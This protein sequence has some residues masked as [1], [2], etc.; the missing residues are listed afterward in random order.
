MTTLRQLSL[1]LFAVLALVV[2]ARAEIVIATN[3]TWRYFK[4][5]SE[6]SDPTNLWREVA[7]D[8]SAWLVGA[9]PFHYG[10]NSL[11]GDDNQLGGTI[12]SDMRSNYTCIFMRQPFVVE[13]TNLFLTLKLGFY[14]DDGLVIWLNGRLAR[15]PIR[16]GANWAYTNAA[17]TQGGEA[18]T[19]NTVD[20]SNVITNLVNGTN[21]LCVQAFNG[22]LTNDDFRIDM[23]LS[24]TYKDIV[25][26]V[27]T[28]ALPAPGSAVSSLT[29]I[30]VQFDE[31]VQGVVAA[32]FLVNGD[33]C[34]AV[35]GSNN[36]YTFTFNQPQP[37]RVQ[38]RW[39]INHTVF[40]LSGN[41]L[42]ETAPTASWEYTLI[43]GTP[44][45]VAAIFPRPGATLT[46]LTELEVIFSEPIAGL[47]AADLLIAGQPAS[48]VVPTAAGGYLFRAT[49]AA[50]GAV[51][52]EWSPTHQI[53]DLAPLPNPFAGG[54]WTY[55]LDLTL[56]FANVTIN[57]F[58]AENLTGLK[59]EDTEEQDW[60]EL[61]N[62]G[63]RAIPLLGWSLTDDPAQPRLWEFPDVSINPGQYLVVFA[64]AKDRKPTTPGS[65]LHTNFRLNPYGDYLGLYNP[66]HPPQAVSEFTPQ[67]PEQR[68]NISYGLPTGTN[69]FAYYAT[70]TPG[71]SNPPA[72]VYL[73]M[74]SAPAASV[75]SGLFNQ[76]F[77]VVLSTTTPGASIYYTLNGSP[78]GPT[79]TLYTAPIPVAGTASK[80][81]VLLRAAAYKTNWLSSPITTH[82]YIFPYYVINQPANPAGFPT[83]WNDGGSKNDIPADYEMD[84]QILTNGNNAATAR[85]GL[86]ALPSLSIVTHVD[87]LFGTNKGLYVLR[88]DTY[89]Q[90]VNAELIF[91]DGTPGFNVPAG[92]EIQ[93]GTS[94]NDEGS[95][96]KSKKLSLRL[97]FKGDFGARNLEYPLFP[98][99]PV[100]RFNTLV[101]DNGLNH[102]W[103]YNG[104]SSTEQQRQTAQYT[105]DQ[106]ISDLQLATGHASAH[107]RYTHVYLNGLYWGLTSLHERPD[108][109][110]SAEHLGGDAA[111]YDVLRHNNNNV[112]A[113]NN[114][115]YNAMF[116]A[117]R[118]G[119]A[120]NAAYE[121]FAQQYL[122]VPAFIDYMIINLWSGNNDWAHQN[123]YASRRRAPGGLWRY[124]SW[125]A[126]HVLEST[127]FNWWT[128]GHASDPNGPT[129]LLQ[130]LR[131]NAEFR[132]TFADH[133]HRHFFNA[134]VFA[135]AA[136]TP[137]NLDAPGGN[138]PAALYLQRVRQVEPVLV[139]ESARWGDAG[140]L[141]TDRSNN[142]LTVE[143]DW[144]PELRTLM[145]LTN[146]GG[147]HN[148]QYN[149]FPNRSATV[150]NQFRANG[151][152]PTVPAPVFRQH[153]GRVPAGYALY[154]TNTAGAGTTV[155]YT[156]TGHDPRLY[157]SGAVAPAARVYTNN[158]PVLLDRTVVLKARAWSNTVWSALVE[159]RFTVGEMGIPLRLTELMY[160][161]LPGG[162]PGE[163]YEFVELQNTGGTPLDLQ[164]YYF[165]G[166]SF[167][168]PPG[169]S[170]NAGARL[171]LASDN[172]PLNWLAR[173]PGVTPAGWFDNAL[174]NAGETITLY[175][176]RGVKVTAVTYGSSRPWP[177][178]ANGQGYSLEIIDAEGDPNDPANWRASA[179]PGGTPGLAPT[180]VTPPTLVL[181]EIMA[182]NVSAVTND[183]AFPDWIELHNPG[184]NP[185]S[186]A[187][188][189]LTDDGNPRKFVFPPSVPDLDAGQ[190]L[191]VW[192]DTN[193]AAPGLHTGFALGRLGENL[194]LYDA[195]TNRVDALSYGP[196]V[197][198][199]TLGR[200][201]PPGRPSD[202]WT[203]CLPT[204]GAAN[205]AALL[206]SATNLVLNEWLANPP[207]GGADWIELYNP[208]ASAPVALRGAYFSFSNTIVQLCSWSFVPA[209]GFVRLWADELPGG[210]HLDFKL[211]KEGG[212]LALYDETGAEVNR[213]N[214]GAQA[215]NVTQ[216]RLPNGSATTVA[217]PNS[218][219]P[220]A[221]NYV[222]AYTGPRLN[223]VLARN[224][225]AV[226]GPS[227]N[228]PDWVELVN[229]NGSAFDLS[230]MSL[231]D[232]PTE[233]GKWVFPAGVSIAANDY[234]VVWCDNSRPAST[235]AGGCLNTGFALDGTSGGV[236][237]FNSLGQR[238]DAVEYGFQLPDVSIGLAGGTWRLL[239]SPTPGSANSTPA[240]LGAVANVRINEW[241]ADTTT[242]SDWF[243]LYNLDSLPVNLAG[244]YLTDDP[245]ITG[246]TNFQVGPL[247]FIGGKSWVVWQ[248]DGDAGEGRDHVNFALDALG[249]TLRLYASPTNLIDAVDFGLQTTNVSRGRLADGAT[250]L[251]SFPTSPS[252]GGANYLPLADVVINEV[253][254]HTDPPLE[255]A[256]ELHNPSTNTVDLSGWYLSNSESDLKRYRIPPGTVLTNGGFTVFYEYQF[257][258]NAG[259]PPSFALNSAHGDEVYLAQATN[260]VLTGYRASV[261]FGAS[262]NG[263]SL[264]RHQTSVGA[265]FVA[266]SAR[267]FGMD[268]PNTLAEFRTGTGLP[269]ADPQVGPLV[270]NEIM[271]HPVSG[272]GGSES[273]DEEFIEIYNISSNTVSLFDPAHTTNRWKLDGAVAYEFP[274]TASLGAGEYLLVVHFDPWS[275]P[276]ALANFQAK[277][278]VATNVPIL[279]PWSGR[280]DNAGEN[281][282]LYQPDAPQTSPPDAGFVPFILVDRVNYDDAAPWPTNGVDGGGASLQRLTSTAYG[283]DPVNWKAEAPT[284]GGE[285][286]A[287]PSVP[288]TLSLQPQS[289]VAIAGNSVVFSVVAAGTAPLSYQWQLDGSNIPGATEASYTIPF[290]QTNDAGNYRVVVSN[291][292]NSIVSQ[293]ASLTVLVPPSIVSLVP[294]SQT[295][296]AGSSVAFTVTAAGTLP[297][298]YQ[299]L[300]NGAEVLDATSPVLTFNNVQPD[301]AGPYRVVVTNLVG[302]VTS[303]VATLTVQV[304]PAITGQPQSQTVTEGSNAVFSVAVTGDPPLSYQWYVNSN[305][306]S[307]ATSATLTVPGALATDDGNQYLVLVSNPAGTVASASATLTVLARPILVG[308]QP[309]P[310]DLVQFTVS[311][312]SHRSYL[313]QTSTNLLANETNWAD[314]G[315]V[316]TNGQ[317]VIL[318]TATNGVQRFY[319]AVLVP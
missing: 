278:G 267:T 61:Y 187:H 115:L 11:G 308:V 81:V 82:T 49:N 230:G 279:G 313:L 155:Y 157:G 33:P 297:L 248:A 186:L 135:V 63:P 147:N 29:Q 189:S 125:D 318:G 4:G 152:Y 120:Q 231:S 214:Y 165:D 55:T 286:V 196:Q 170:L 128:S 240:A 148:A 246:I 239:S 85:A 309:L 35:A 252:P 8:D 198:D 199:Y 96:W 65:R 209:G 137:V 52:V 99:T 259:V 36:T 285:N 195:N 200:D 10:T 100:T 83:W 314:T 39:D 25:P 174:A 45:T 224:Q 2:P 194:F 299:W 188:W 256:I 66:Q 221:S 242:G 205:Q 225:S 179:A 302:A 307:G 47:D 315:L 58:S 202:T 185:V 113:G 164:G 258:P 310:D 130:L 19:F 133:V 276:T 111:E 215:E 27:V 73:G 312:Q 235:N 38:T 56:D 294:L 292:V 149:Y 304:P 112:V 40:D 265:D 171:V 127:S 91:P 274:A 180:P 69:A 207:T 14:Y 122:D 67:F 311:G 154:L 216:G 42:V 176:P 57:E 43:D 84:T 17:S 268:G 167:Q 222:V 213:I 20:V 181:N 168:F 144:R 245:S 284:A 142:P 77:Q 89:Q 60:I 37:G 141:Y 166:I 184:T 238:M 98:D 150:L 210:D 191:V 263:V 123:W 247:S 59:D 34:T 162:N 30:T 92:L 241:M 218:P 5:T 260:D 301:D 23:E 16:V 306:I 290:V 262:E 126:E 254:A 68:P 261:R 208:L 305:L 317:T 134:G 107:W 303:A 271:Y 266:L 255:D 264:G 234:L 183:G 93:G 272:G 103:H 145:G 280:L 273:P 9:A 223:E 72:P 211:P 269:N 88:N 193:T 229:T 156:T 44:P 41:R 124:Y 282:E 160:N 3:S 32:D 146:A 232:S 15:A 173:Y 76:P 28:N 48:S 129:E 95:S 106:Y 243:E 212:A 116:T 319:R 71:A 138:Q 251:V 46:N 289:Q 117:A 80:A 18:S 217:F 159:A 277:Y 226:V 204:P 54:S 233:P 31:P 190:Y 201:G 7:F 270:I 206:A 79:N 131:T 6:A 105:R 24:A 21:W 53:S 257:N 275:N 298:R 94:P 104:G 253:L 250:N 143:G 295:V 219:S 293:P 26:P 169:V 197:P 172:A 316:C 228:Y 12:L 175:D 244:L 281:V 101:L 192:C 22:H 182:D 50:P 86:L 78:P 97:L 121:A 132:L 227:G 102:V 237:L 220:E 158:V 288:P 136:A 119:L 203:L 139:G 249:E 70:S 62:R 291:A 151:V 1:L 140:N 110:W 108:D 51:S 153:G 64:S 87:L 287:G 178:Q 283:N 74:A 177:P 163:P 300:F 13:D 161:P 118:A 236:Y 114:T 296:I 109:H 90:P 75:K